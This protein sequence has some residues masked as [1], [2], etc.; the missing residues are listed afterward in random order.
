M[1]KVGWRIKRFWT[2]YVADH[3]EDFFYERHSNDICGP[4]YH[5]WREFKYGKVAFIISILTL[6]GVILLLIIK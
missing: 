4:G 1:K 2:F 3:I 6:I 5:S